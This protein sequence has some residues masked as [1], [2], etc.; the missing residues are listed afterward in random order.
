MMENWMS[1][2]EFFIIYCAAENDGEMP[3]VEYI[4]AR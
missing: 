2:I 3:P 1:H 4:I